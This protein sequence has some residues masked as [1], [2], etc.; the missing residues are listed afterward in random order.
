MQIFKSRPTVN[1][2][3]HHTLLAVSECFEVELSDGIIFFLILHVAVCYGLLLSIA[4]RQ[5]TINILFFGNEFA[6]MT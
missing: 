4:F 1:K 6:S 3:K 5:Q 2:R